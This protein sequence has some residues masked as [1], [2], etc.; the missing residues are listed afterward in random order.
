MRKVLYLL[1]I[2][3]LL[4]GCS[5]VKEVE[6][7]QELD[8]LH[9]VV[10]H[11]D[12]GAE[13]RT[14][15]QEDGGVWWSPGDEISLYVG[16]GNNQYRLISNS[17]ESSPKTDFVGMVGEG[18]G[19]YYA[20]SPYNSAIGG[21]SFTIPTV[22][23]STKGSFTSE[24]MISYAYSNDD[25]LT[26][27][28]TCAGIKFSVTQEGIKK[29][30]F[31]NREDSEPIAGDMYVQFFTSFPENPGIIPQYSGSS[32]SL[33]VY[34]AEGD[35]FIPGEFYYASLRPGNTSL[36]ISFFTETQSATVALYDRWLERSTIVTLREVDKDLSFTKQDNHTYATLGASVPLLPD[37]VNKDDIKEVV[38]HTS[39]NVKTETIVPC[40]IPRYVRMGYYDIEYYPVYFELIGST[41]HFYTE[42]ERYRMGGVGCISFAEW[43]ELRHVDLSMFDTSQVSDFQH[44]FWNCINLESV[45]LSSFDTNNGRSFFDMFAGCKKLRELD[46]SNFSSKNAIYTYVSPFSGI[47]N[48]CHSLVSLDLGYFN[49]SGEVDHGMFS[50]ARNSHNCAIRCTPGTREALSNP[51]TRLSNNVN[52]TWV[53]PDEEMPHVEPYRF[54]YYSSDFSDDK[55]FRVLQKASVGKGINIILM[56]DGYSDR[57][58]ND[59]TYDEDMTKAMN[60]IFKDEPYA[61]F[62]EYFNV[63]LVYAVSENEIPGESYTTFGTFIGG[64]DP[65]NG[66]VAYHEDYYVKMYAR[67]PDVDIDETCIVLVLNQEPGFVAGVATQGWVMEGEDVDVVSDYAKGGS[68]VMACRGRQ[69]S[70]DYYSFVVAHEFGHGFAKLADEYIVY[71]GMMEDGEKEE[72]LRLA[73]NYG[74]WKNID[75]TDN[76]AAIKWNHFLN[77]ERY[78]GTVGIFEGATYTEGAWRPSEYSIMHNDIT[79]MFNAPSREAIYKRIH[80]LAFGKEWQYDYE[81]F[82]EYDQ[83]NIAAEK[84][85][86]SAPMV[87]RPPVPEMLGKPF[88]KIEKSVMPDGKE[89]VK[90][91]MN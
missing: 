82:V 38:F 75:F 57:M 56:G 61:S 42:A 77:D 74:W 87:L 48:N 12:W 41:A 22:Q 11:A 39:S 60:A 89:R 51:I 90:V 9:E 44:M 1:I 36:V 53:L 52:I 63:Y 85:A 3:V 62:K 49:I 21:T 91:I 35:Y 59:G 6:V 45:N 5:K 58:I 83:K 32:N 37:G 40:S 73:N 7:P 78:T 8:G 10:F 25:H 2:P 28:N 13:T 20:I 33:T 50:F 88:M 72:Y 71:A 34:P 54:D 79:G 31:K 14:I 27:Y 69:S 24:Q 18:E 67:I 29:I 55:T 64:M 4:I 68:V 84:A 81:T 26:F 46:I 65:E 70:D 17:S 47:F 19:P 86:L 16:S 15:L 76:P 30:V 80:R 23:Y 66:A 43:H